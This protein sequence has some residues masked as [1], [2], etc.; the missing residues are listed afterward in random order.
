MLFKKMLVSNIILSKFCPFVLFA[1]KQLY[2]FIL[3]HYDTIKFK[4]YIHGENIY[5]DILF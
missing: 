1:D 5:C 2:W 4:I 3:F